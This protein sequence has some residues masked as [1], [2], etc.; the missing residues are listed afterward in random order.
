[1]E[2]DQRMIIKLLENEG[3]DARNI[4]DRLQ[5]D[6]RHSLVNIL[7]NFE[8]FDSGLQRHGSMVKTCMM[9]FVPEDLRLMILT[10]KFWWYW[11]NL[12]LNSSQLIRQLRDCLLLI[13]ECCGICM[14]ALASNRFICVRYRICWQMIYARNKRS[15]HELCCHSCMPPNVM[16]GIISWLV[17][18]HDFSSIHY[19]VAYGRYREMIWSKKP[20]LDIQSKKSCLQSYGIRTASALLTDSQI[21]PK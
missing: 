2:H 9:K 14:I 15:M 6:W 21:I 5:T 19:H 13:Q 12:R 3:A 17:M 4:G 20:R 16:A 10:R 11:T 8:W 18:S 1:M 7:V